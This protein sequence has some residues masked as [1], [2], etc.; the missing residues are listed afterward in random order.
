MTLQA[1]RRN[2]SLPGSPHPN[3]VVQPLTFVTWAFPIMINV[4]KDSPAPTRTP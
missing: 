1:A 3:M 2:K 4:M